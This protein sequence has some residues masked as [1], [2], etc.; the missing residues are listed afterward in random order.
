MAHNNF[1][2]AVAFDAKGLKMLSGGEV[3][4]SSSPQSPS[5][6]SHQPST[7]PPTLNPLNT[8]LSLRLNTHRTLT[9]Q[10]AFCL[11]GPHHPRVAAA[12]ARGAPIAARG[13]SADP[14][15]PDHSPGL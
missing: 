14:E 7:N 2:T 11:P 9:L 3:S 12:D 8:H 13:G 4:V 10:S 5:R 6:N 1:V 15:H